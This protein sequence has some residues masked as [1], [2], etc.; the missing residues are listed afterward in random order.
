[1]DDLDYTFEQKL[2]GVVSLLQ[3]EA[4]QCWLTVKEG[5][6]PDR[7]TWEFFKTAFQ[8]KYVGTSYVDAW[9]REILNLFQGDKSVAEYKAE[10]LRLSHYVRWIVAT[11]Y[12]C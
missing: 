6:Q 4:Y 2:K 10:F 1:M 12:E 9:R 7:L 3:D 5:T 11:E 8:G